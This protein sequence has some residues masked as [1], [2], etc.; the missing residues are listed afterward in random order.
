MKK[1]II[2]LLIALGVGVIVYVVYMQSFQPKYPGT[3]EFVEGDDSCFVS[4]EFSSG[5]KGYKGT[6]L[7]QM[8]GNEEIAYLGGYKMVDGKM[9]VDI[10]NMDDIA[11]IELGHEKEGKKL[12]LTYEWE[13][14]NLQ[15]TYEK[16]TK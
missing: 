7:K 2:A 6:S 5:P 12:L 8:D 13:G 11:P 9:V 4:V 15:C 10:F 14:A 16:K 1:G 3:W